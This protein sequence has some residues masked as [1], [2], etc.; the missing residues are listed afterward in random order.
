MRHKEIL[1]DACGDRGVDCGKERMYLKSFEED[2]L[3]LYPIITPQSIQRL[4]TEFWQ[5]EQ[6]GHFQSETAGVSRKRKHPPTEDTENPAQAIVLLALALGQ[7]CH[8]QK[9]TPDFT[10]LGGATHA[11]GSTESYRFIPGSEWFARARV[12]ISAQFADTSLQHLQMYVLAGLYEGLV[13]RPQ[14]AWDYVCS[15]IRI[16]RAWKGS[17]REDNH[18][19]LLSLWACVELEW[20]DTP[21]ICQTSG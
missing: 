5:Q 10:S 3:S 17:S 2:I 1:Q 8:Q 9:N 15:A 18:L 13:G 21:P 19:R 12:I 4:V 7:F 6:A 20:Y 14:S 16:A 11:Y